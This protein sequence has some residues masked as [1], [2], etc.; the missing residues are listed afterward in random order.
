M[1]QREGLRDW[2][3]LHKRK[4]KEDRRDK[5]GKPSYGVVCLSNEKGRGST[6]IVG[7]GQ[8]QRALSSHVNRYLERELVLTRGYFFKIV[9][10][11]KNYA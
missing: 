9:G 8:R 11:E 2:V 4:E 5:G 7:Y 6:R 10:I 1:R 3:G